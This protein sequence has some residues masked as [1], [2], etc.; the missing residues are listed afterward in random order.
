M[1]PYPNE[2]SI[3]RMVEEYRICK[4]AGDCLT[5]RASLRQAHDR[6][7]QY[8]QYHLNNIH[9]T[10]GLV[11]ILIAF[12]AILSLIKPF[13][14]KLTAGFLFTSIYI[15]PV[16]ALTLAIFGSFWLAFGLCFSGNCSRDTEQLLAIAPGLAMLIILVIIWPKVHRKRK[17]IRKQL[18]DHTIIFVTLLCLC[19]GFIVIRLSDYYARGYKPHPNYDF[20]QCEVKKKAAKKDSLVLSSSYCDSSTI[21]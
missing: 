1:Y 10:S 3:N 15:L 17:V 7:D 21:E 14:S 2:E 13:R 19:L 5:Y 4:S 11:L 20:V 6:I 16:L 12:V 18:D 8:N 9:R